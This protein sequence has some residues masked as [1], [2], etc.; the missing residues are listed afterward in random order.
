MPCTK[1]GHTLLYLDNDEICPKCEKLV[2]LDPD[3]AVK[4]ATR[5]VKL[6]TKIFNEELEKWE[7]DTL[8]GNLAAKLELYSRQFLENTAHSK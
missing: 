2:V 1:C 5:L 4:V 8:L 6:S 3:T 7:M